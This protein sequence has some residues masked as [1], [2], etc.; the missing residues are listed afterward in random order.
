MRCNSK[1]CDFPI[2]MS[3]YIAIFRPKPCDRSYWYR[4]DATYSNR[5]MNFPIRGY[6]LCKNWGRRVSSGRPLIKIVERECD[7]AY[8]VNIAKS[9]NVGTFKGKRESAKITDGGSQAIPGYASWW[10]E[11]LRL[12]RIKI[13]AVRILAPWRDWRPFTG[14]VLRRAV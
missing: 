3:I 12:Q 9:P 5:Y 8:R 10:K 7:S 14:P 11:N 1:K 2:K 6:V 4:Y 13:I